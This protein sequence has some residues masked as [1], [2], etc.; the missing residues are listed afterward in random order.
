[1]KF[2]LF[3]LI[4][5]A[6]C[7]AT[8]A[9]LPVLSQDIKKHGLKSVANKSISNGKVISGN[10]RK[11]DHEG[12]ISEDSYFNYNPITKITNKSTNQYI[13]RDKQIVKIFHYVNDIL[14]DST[15]H[16][17]EWTIEK[18]VLEDFSFIISSGQQIHRVSIFDSLV[19]TERRFVNDTLEQE[20]KRYRYI[21]NDST[22]AIVDIWDYY[23]KGNKRIISRDSSV[24]I[25]TPDYYGSVTWKNGIKTESISRNYKD[26]VYRHERR[27]E[28]N[29]KGKITR[30]YEIWLDEKER[31]IKVTNKGKKS[32]YNYTKTFQYNENISEGIKT[33]EKITYGKKHKMLERH[34]QTYDDKNFPQGNSTYNA[35][36]IL[37]Y[38]MEWEYK[39][40]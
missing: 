26:S 25:T 21:I 23:Y 24:Q 36:G 40:W 16:K 4:F 12:N 32:R 7:S 34:V 28:Y 27:I 20:E 14:S 18:R 2:I 15:L 31:L 22:K 9:Q 10:E 11:Y 37:I 29:E 17:V 30:E 35:K 33:E 3:I 13:Y 5:F 8:N 39:Y 6:C 19:H 1:M 38:K